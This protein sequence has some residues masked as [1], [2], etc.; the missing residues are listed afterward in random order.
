MIEKLS[1]RKTIA[2]IIILYVMLYVGFKLIIV[3]YQDLYMSNDI[4]D[5]KYSEAKTINIKSYTKEQVSET[6]YFSN[7]S[8]AYKMKVKNYFD[9]FEAGDADTNYEYYM[10]YDE[11][12]KVNAAFMM[13]Q[14]DTEIKKIDLM[15]KSSQY[16]EFNYFPQYISTYLR[17]KFLSKHNIEND[18]DLIKYI[19]E[20]EKLNCTFFTPLISIKEN[21][22]FNFIEATLPD[23]NNVTYIEGD[24]EGYIIEEDGYK[25]AC[26][27]K[28]D[29][30]YCLTFFKLEYFNDEIIED[31]LKSLIIEK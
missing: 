25:M 26:I 17:D 16:Y 14:F 24:I 5:I 30:L 2:L 21:Y 19:R 3:Y 4:Y 23:I 28:D 18:I 10:L 11:N 20:R 31:V 7:K 27:V 15:D 13:G 1:K 8:D 22:F 12:D 29:K 6:T 9:G